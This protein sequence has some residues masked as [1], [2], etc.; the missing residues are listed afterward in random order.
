M[1]E[2]TKATVLKTVSGATRSWVRIPLLPQRPSVFWIELALTESPLAAFERSGV[3][4]PVAP[5]RLSEARSLLLIEDNLSNLTLVERILESRPHVTVLSAMQGGLGLDLARQ[6]RPDLILLD[7]HLPD[8]PGHEVLH[9][10]RAD[11]ETLTIP[12]VIVSADATESRIRRLMEAGALD[13]LTKPIDV[14]RLL[15]LVDA[16]LAEAS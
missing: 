1:A 14:R 11:P 6:H 12:V 10:L 8:V 3:G 4:V 16:H 2:R 9:R 5:A 13:Y 7:L 15:E